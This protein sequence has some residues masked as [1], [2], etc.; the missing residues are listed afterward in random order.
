MRCE[1]GAELHCGGAS[2]F[3]G[4]VGAMLFV[5]TVFRAARLYFG[6]IMYLQVETRDVPWWCTRRL[7][8]VSLIA[9]C[10]PYRMAIVK[11]DICPSCP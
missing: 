5:H 6:Y 7:Q 4:C 3:E 9:G 11:V 8:L 1:T 10:T 2:G